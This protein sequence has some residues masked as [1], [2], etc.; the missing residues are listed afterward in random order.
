MRKFLLALFAVLII[1]VSG[2][3]SDLSAHQAQSLKDINATISVVHQLSTDNQITSAQES[4]IDAF[5]LNKAATVVGHPVTASDVQKLVSNAD[6]TQGLGVFLNFAIVLAGVIGLL[7][8]VAIIAYYLRDVLKEI[9]AEVYEVLAYIGTAGLAL[10]GYVHPFNLGAVLVEPLWFTVPGALALAA[11]LSLTH[12]LHFKS[13]YRGDTVKMGPGFINFPTVM[14]GLC[15]AAWGSMALLYSHIYPDSGIP[16]VLAFGAV[17]A[18][19]ACLGFS[20]ITM[21]GCIALGWERDSQV[22]R[23]VFSSFIILVAYLWLTLSGGLTGNLSLFAPGAIFM[24]AFVY[25][26]G[27]LVMANKWYLSSNKGNSGQYMLMQFIT[28][29]SGFLAFYLGGTFHIGALLGVGGTFFAIYLLEKF[30]EIPWKGIG[31]A[32]ALVGTAVFLYF[33]VG[34]ANTHSQYFVWGIR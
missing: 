25:Y 32:W 9:P 22:P 15:T 21:P 4:Q 23:S 26:L 2:Y 18:L 7:G 20:A 12:K 13:S 11:S 33:L 28:I 1:P 6:K 10:C 34:Y 17:I 27:L 16:N 19:Q 8:V 31:W 30:Y 24:G 29:V 5:Y 3:C 14:F